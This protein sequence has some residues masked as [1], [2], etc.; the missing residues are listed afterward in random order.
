MYESCQKH[1]TP[2]CSC[3]NLVLCGF[4]CAS[5]LEARTNLTL[6]PVCDIDLIKEALNDWSRGKELILIPENRNRE[7]RLRFEGNKI[8]CFPTDQS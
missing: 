6:C 3:T 7:E 5:G 2:N 1:I 8:N 4:M